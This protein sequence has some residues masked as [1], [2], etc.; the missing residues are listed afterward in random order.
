MKNTGGFVAKFDVHYK[1][2]GK[3]ISKD[4]GNFSAGI[5]KSI[6]IPEGATEISLKIKEEYAISSWST[7][8]T[9]TFDSPPQKCYEVYG[10]TLDAHA[11]S[12]RCPN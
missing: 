2:D 9:E 10:S 4:S 3:E 8:L 5:S 1:S 6:V 11:K 7:V 12:V